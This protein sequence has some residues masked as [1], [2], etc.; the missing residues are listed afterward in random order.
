MSLKL[1][2]PPPVVGLVCA[3]I[4]WLAS[5]FF[6]GFSFNLPYANFISPGLICLA[7]FIDISALLNFKS[8]KTTINPMKPGESSS[9]AERGVYQYTRNPMYL[10]LLII[11]SSW[12]I[13]LGNYISVLVLPFFVWYITVF[14]IIPEEEILENK[15]KEKY[16]QYKH[17]VRRWI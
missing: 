7:L 5:R 3:L 13:F 6:T 4:M 10:G 9:L 12:G 14:Q 1:K 2:I 16:M 17:K 11:L 15:F 8:L